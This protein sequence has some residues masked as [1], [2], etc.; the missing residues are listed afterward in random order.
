MDLSIIIINYKSA[1]HVINCVKSIYQETTA[2]R[3]E[4]IVVDNQSGDDSQERILALF[5]QVIWVQTGYNAGFARA[6][7]AG[8]RI[9]GG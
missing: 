4:I 2:H 1:Q 3:F 7:N 8:I 6:Y 9:A 5:P